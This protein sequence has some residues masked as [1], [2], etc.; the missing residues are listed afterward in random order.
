MPLV[1]RNKEGLTMKKYQAFEMEIREIA[2]DVITTSGGQNT[3]EAPNVF[4]DLVVD[5]GLAN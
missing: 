4:D 2:V 1:M 5:F 3:V